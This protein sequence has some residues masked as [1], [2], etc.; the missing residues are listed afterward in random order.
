MKI[1]RAM[2]QNYALGNNML[3]QESNYSDK[4]DE[5][6]PGFPTISDR[7]SGEVPKLTAVG[8]YF[9]VIQLITIEVFG[10][11]TQWSQDHRRTG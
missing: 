6:F 2:N 8:V 5:I 10:S 4:S 1:I 11:P 9:A 3:C 7:F